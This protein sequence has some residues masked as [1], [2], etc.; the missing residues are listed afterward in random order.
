MQLQ[1]IRL[2]NDTMILYLKKMGKSSKRNEI[3]NIILKDDSCFFK[4]NKEDAHIILEDIGIE[5]DKVNLIYSNLTSSDNYYKL[6]KEGKINENDDDIILKYKNY[7]YDDL[8]KQNKSWIK[9][10]HIVEN[11]TAISKYKESILKKI[12][13]KIR[14]IFSKN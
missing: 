9:E 8:F 12:I 10:N 1:D 6:Q 2:M 13:N 7:E 4:M 5:K 3:I 11:G 14:N